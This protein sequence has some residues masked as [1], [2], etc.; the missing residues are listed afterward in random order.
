MLSLTVCGVLGRK[1]PAASRPDEKGRHAGGLSFDQPGVR[2]LGGG[3]DLQYAVVL[4]KCPFIYKSDQ[5]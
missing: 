3:E 4:E 1:L 2:V 5:I